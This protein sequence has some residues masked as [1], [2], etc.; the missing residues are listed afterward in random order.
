MQKL[1]PE[2]V[3][4]DD[5]WD[6]IAAVRKFALGLAGSGLLLGL[7][8][9]GWVAQM[10]NDH[11]A[12]VGQVQARVGSN[13]EQVESAMASQ[14]RIEARLDE[15]ARFLREDSREQREVMQD[16]VRSMHGGTGK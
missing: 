7:A 6:E 12:D 8:G 14:Q 5:L 11:A 4:H 15:I 3:S 10:E 9:F 16:H 1:K 2:H 13:A